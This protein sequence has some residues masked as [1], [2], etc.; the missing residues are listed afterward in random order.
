M[1]GAGWRMSGGVEFGSNLRRSVKE[2]SNKRRGTSILLFS[3]LSLYCC[4]GLSQRGCAVQM[5]AARL[6]GRE[7]NSPVRCE[8]Q[9]GRDKIVFEGDHLAAGGQVPKTQ[10]SIAAA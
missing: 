8:G 5:D 3:R 6:L 1:S 2:V 9:P 7:E 10:G 4:V